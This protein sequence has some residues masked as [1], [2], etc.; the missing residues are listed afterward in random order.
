MRQVNIAIGVIKQGDKY[1]LQ[2]RNGDPKI[3][4]AG[5]VGC[6]GGKISEGE[7]PVVTFCREVAEETAMRPKPEEVEKLGVVKVKSDH[8]LE[9]VRVTGHVFHWE[10]KNPKTPKVKEGELIIMS[11]DD[12]M[13]G[14][15][16]FTTGTRAVFE[17]LL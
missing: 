2:L 4:Q 10:L 17:E 12:A 3:G 6:F 14:L 5:L 16:N 1:L 8:N 15:S 13:A 7:D 9:S 11:H